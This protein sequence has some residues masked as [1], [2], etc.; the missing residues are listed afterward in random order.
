VAFFFAAS[1]DFRGGILTAATLFFFFGVSAGT[2]SVTALFLLLSRVVRVFTIAQSKMNA[3]VATSRRLHKLDPLDPI[4]LVQR[5]GN[6]TLHCNNKNT[7]Q[8]ANNASE[9]KAC[10]PV[11][12]QC[13][14]GINQHD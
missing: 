5:Y 7:T 11:W 14:R 12:K 6:S 8:G 10:V 1:G 3:S 9:R 2:G 4:F 13:L